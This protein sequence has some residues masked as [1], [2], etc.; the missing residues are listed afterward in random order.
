MSIESGKVREWLREAHGGGSAV[1]WVSR[2]AKGAW[3]IVTYRLLAVYPTTIPSNPPPPGCQNR[4][5]VS[6]PYYDTTTINHGKSFRYMAAHTQRDKGKFQ[7]QLPWHAQC[8]L[9][10]VM[11]LRM[12][13][14]TQD[15]IVAEF[16]GWVSLDRRPAQVQLAHLNISRLWSF[17]SRRQSLYSGPLVSSLERDLLDFMDILH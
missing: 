15:S 13:S 10:M 5:P 14:T 8:R 16:R 9:H 7:P 17:G 1:P 4:G 3:T 12:F 11:P 2:R 6:Q